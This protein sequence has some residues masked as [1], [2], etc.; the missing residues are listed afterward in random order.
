MRSENFL[1]QKR[2]Q[3]RVKPGGKLL[4]RERRS[5]SQSGGRSRR[6]GDPESAAFLAR[7]FDV[8]PDEALSFTHGLHPYPARLHPRIAERLIAA[9]AAPGLILDPFVG[10]GTVAVEAL[11]AGREFVGNDLLRVPLEIAWAR[12]RVWA[13]ARCE[14]LVRSAVSLARRSSRAQGP[15]WPVWV[16][17][18]SDWFFPHTLDELLAL[19][20]A[21]EE[22]EPQRSRMLRVVWSSLLVKYS[23]QVSDSVTKVDRDARRW[24][25]GA[26]LTGFVRRAE[27]TAQRLFALAR[28][29]KERKVAWSE[30]CW[31]C[32][33]AR[34]LELEPGSVAGIVSSPPYP[35]HY[36][37]ARHLWLREVLMFGPPEDA[38]SSRAPPELGSRSEWNSRS[39]AAARFS[40]DLL[41]ALRAWRPALASGAS[42]FLVIGDGVTEG[43]VLRTDL[44]LQ[45]LAGTAGLR[46]V[47]CA[48]QERREWSFD[49]KGLVKHEHLVWLRTDS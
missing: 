9:V 42:V 49:Q 29:L 20:C 2:E 43:G 32:S 33:D 25:R 15:E 40:A 34:A 26:V 24:P 41:T 45:E 12:T 7:C 48:S 8:D 23:R 31:R 1:G 6:S 28:D 19:R 35:G 17:T 11:R 44:L 4:R 39:D 3:R 18:L 21:I 30:P 36:D 5:L 37:Y 16:R 46:F 10:S 22:L 47:A 14:A 13:P 27:E 38:R